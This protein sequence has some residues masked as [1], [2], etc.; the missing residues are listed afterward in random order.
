[1]HRVFWV[2]GAR[3]PRL[4]MPLLSRKSR[5]PLT[6]LNAYTRRERCTKFT[7]KVSTDLASRAAG[8]ATFSRVYLIRR[9]SPKS[10]GSPSSPIG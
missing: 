4:R 8:R 2:E 6:A 3:R 10:A 1:M 5:T 7:L 9:G